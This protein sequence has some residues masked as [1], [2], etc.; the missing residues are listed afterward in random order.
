[1]LQINPKKLKAIKNKSIP[2]PMRPR[3]RNKNQTNIY[4]LSKKKKNSEERIKFFNKVKIVSIFLI[5]GLSGY[6]IAS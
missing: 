1:M 6:Y 3:F 4:F 5:V 2:S